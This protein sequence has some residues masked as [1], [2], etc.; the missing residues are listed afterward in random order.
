[1]QSKRNQNP[2][3]YPYERWA[4]PSCNGLPKPG[5]SMLFKVSPREGFAPV[6]PVVAKHD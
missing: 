3:P 6:C 4:A 1:M 5:V 2:S